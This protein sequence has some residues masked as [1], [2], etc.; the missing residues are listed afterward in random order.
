MKSIH[1]QNRS[2]RFSVAILSV[3]LAITILVGGLPQSE[4]AAVTCKYKHTVQT[5]E[6]LMYI[7]S[8]YQVN[9][10]KIAEANNLTQP[11]TITAGQVLC[12]PYG[13][14]VT[15]IPTTKKGSEAKVTII[16]SLGNV[17]VAVENFPK[18]MSYYV[19]VSPM[20]TSNTYHIG[21]FTTNKEGDFTGWFKIPRT[22]PL[23]AHME[24]CIKNVWT[25]SVSCF[26]YTDPYIVPAYLYPTC[27]HKNEPR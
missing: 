10:E 15:N 3:F 25:D 19:R 20:G 4:A 9:W 1:M 13:E 16:P 8:L 17:L 12:I 7:S 24:L 23:T 2:S 6:T 26:T 14:N 18:K 5:G 11:Y 21:Y 27:H 22:V